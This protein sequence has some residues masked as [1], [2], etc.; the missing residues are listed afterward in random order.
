MEELRGIRSFE[1][2]NHDWGGCFNDFVGLNCLELNVDNLTRNWV[3]VDILYDSKLFLA[4]DVEI[5]WGVVAGFFENFFGRNVFRRSKNWLFAN[6]P[7]GAQ[8][9]AVIYS[10]IE[11]AKENGLDPYRYLLWIFREAPKAAASDPAW[12]GGF[13]PQSAPKSL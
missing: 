6:T 3:D 5:N 2:C 10:L 11:T 13:L 7:A 1:V 12:A 9:S 4:S 8:S